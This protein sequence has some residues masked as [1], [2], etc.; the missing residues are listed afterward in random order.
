LAIFLLCN[1]VTCSQLDEKKFI[2]YTIQH[3]LSDNSVTALTQDENGFLWIGTQNGLNR[4]DG[5]EFR[6]LFGSAGDNNRIDDVNKFLLNR[7]QLLITTR[8]GIQS[9]DISNEQVTCYRSENEPGSSYINDAMDALPASNGEVLMSSITGLYLFAKNRRFNFRYD[10]YSVGGNPPRSYGRNLAALPGD[11]YIHFTHEGIFIFNNRLKK[12]S[13]IA[14]YKKQFPNLANAGNSLYKLNASVGRYKMVLCN[15]VNNQL[16]FYDGQTDHLQPCQVPAFFKPATGWQMNWYAINDTTAIVTSQKSGFYICYFNTVTGQIRAEQKCYFE[17]FFCT[18]VLKDKEGRIWIGTDKGLFKQDVVE[19]PVQTFD[20]RT[21]SQG[22]YKENCEIMAFYRHRNELYVGAYGKEAIYV[23]DATTLSYKQQISFAR[24]DPKCNQV[25]HIVS[26]AKDTLWF[27]TQNGLV[28][29]H[30]GNKHFGYVELPPEIRSYL[31]EKPISIAFKDSHQLL[32]L[33]GAW[34][35]GVIQY[36]PYTK[37]TRIFQG[38]DTGQLPVKSPGLIAEDR[39]S[40]IWLASRGL[41]RWNRQKDRFD[42]LM[43][44]YTGFNADNI[45]IIALTGGRQQ[46]IV[47]SNRHNGVVFFNPVEKKYFQLTTS[48]GLPENNIRVLLNVNKSHTWI[49]GRNYLSAWDQQTQRLISYS[50]TDGIPPEGGIPSIMYHDTIANRIYIGYTSGYIAWV[51][52]NMQQTETGSIPF[53]IDVVSTAGKRAFVYP[54]GDLKLPYYDNDIRIHVAAINFHDE[55]NN[56]IWYRTNATEPWTILERQNTLNFNNLAAGTYQ[57]EIKVT[58][59]SSRWREVVRKLTIIIQ[60]PFWQT[61]WFYALVFF[62]GAA[63]IFTGVRLRIKS[64]QRTADLNSRLAITEMKALHAQMNPHFIF[65]SLNSIREMILQNENDKASHYL[66]RFARLIRMN[67]HQSRQNFIS[68]D[69]NIQY[70]HR[71]LEME[72]LRFNDF[73]YSVTIDKQ[74][75]ITQ[76]EIPPMLLQPLIENAIWHGLKPKA[77]YKNIDIRFTKMHDQLVCEIEDNG[78][79]IGQAAQNKQLVNHQ[80]VGIDNIRDRIRLLNSKYHI[81][82]KLEIEEINEK[83]GIAATGTLARLTLSLTYE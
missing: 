76:V 70:L 22:N 63:V 23:F 29:L 4:F 14:A 67:L 32:W 15:G 47:F 6:K 80:S 60:P 11:L 62:I 66:V 18:A 69:Q 20:L 82:C 35:S 59:A 46:S 50:F 36:D 49:A 24:L 68:L 38:G 8:K 72:K 79:G 37:Y 54:S 41:T 83:D 81:S 3:G 31:Y 75:N 5:S 61:T 44:S 25:W 28:W 43:E 33:Q 7:H 30:T 57:L 40:N 73:D 42:T 13:P 56:R 10:R 77:G 2:R 16:F 39:E 74:L 53:F 9:L 65:N 64:I 55:Q 45:H 48:E 34:G 58:S 71:Y 27:A 19:K 78:I 12:Y 1:T 21:F 26:I 52:N 17:D 51:T